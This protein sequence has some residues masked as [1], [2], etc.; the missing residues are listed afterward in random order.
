LCI[1][2]QSRNF[3]S[4]SCAVAVPAVARAVVFAFHFWQFAVVFPGPLL[5]VVVV[6][7]GVG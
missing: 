4:L 2:S 6:G 1:F 5:L 3:C 7:S